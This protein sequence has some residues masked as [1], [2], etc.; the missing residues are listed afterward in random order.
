[1]KQFLGKLGR[2][3]WSW[4]FLK[5]VICAIALIIFLYLEEDWRGARTWAATKAKWEAK[6][7]AFDMNRLIPPP[8]PDD[9]NLAALPL[10]KLEP[11][12]K[13]NGNLK[14]FALQRA[15]RADQPGHD[16]STGGL[17]GPLSGRLPDM[18][19]I[20]D[21]VA[22]AYTEAFKTAPLP[23]DTLAQFDALY[24]FV[25]E[26]RAAAATRPYCHFEQNYS[27]DH[28][29]IRLLTSQIALARILALHAILA[30]DAHQPDLA[31]DDLKLNF[32]LASG[33][34]E[35]P[36]LVSSLCGMGVTAI[37]LHAIC[38]GMALHTWNDAQL[39]D[40][41]KE[42]VHID[43]LSNYQQAM[44]GEAGIAISAFNSLKSRRPAYVSELNARNQSDVSK[45]KISDMFP[46]F[47]ADGWIDLMKVQAVNLDLNA[48]RFVD[49]KTRMVFPKMV[50]PF[51]AG[52]AQR[53]HGWSHDLWHLLTD[54][55]A[56]PIV[57]TV[58]HFAEGQVYIDEAQ[59]AIA[60]E[61][62]RLAHGA[63]PA[64]LDALA[65]ACIDAVPHDIMNGEPYHYRLQ[66][67]GTYLLYSVGWN[68]TD[69][70]GKI[71]Y[72]KESPNQIDYEQGDW[73]WFGPK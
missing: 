7:E 66:P 3:F 21:G 44:R 27:F 60:L 50:D 64:S 71:V 45:R 68:L 11:D 70:G 31:L 69:D 34:R 52:N 51:A 18:K 13:N 5:F 1:M 30:L 49:P 73:A 17:G 40:L 29:H 54:E 28:L 42:L 46:D 58:Q 10:F 59:I 53:Q 19:K 4:G 22:R 16:L 63:Y 38:D 36:V 47:W 20:Q 26:L 8:V 43:Y 15:L 2:F 56:G 62:Y 33:L 65:P 12:P 9:Q 55:A 41:Q 35:Q 61:R 32:K 57:A 6:G 23:K 48:V 24:P 25:A 14:P 39:A 72:K 37:G 67:D